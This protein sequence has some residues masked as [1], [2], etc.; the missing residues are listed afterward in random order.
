[1][2]STFRETVL[3]AIPLATIELSA[4]HDRRILHLV[5]IDRAQLLDPWPTVLIH[6]RLR[7]RSESGRQTSEKTSRV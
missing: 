7:G 6:G 1:M 5:H 2:P 3:V 4:K